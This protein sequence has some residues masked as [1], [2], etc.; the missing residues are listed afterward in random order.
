MFPTLG[1]VLVLENEPLISLD[2]EQMLK[3]FGASAVTTFDTG[4]DALDWLASNTPDLAIVDPRLNDGVCA[5]LGERLV[6]AQVPFVVYSG[7]GVDDPIFQ[8][9]A[10][11]DKP[12]M[13]EIF[14]GTLRRLLG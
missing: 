2:T 8:A 1:H 5:D 11:L 6:A 14:E 4:A 7:A 13:P 10:W 9:R 12:T 3:D